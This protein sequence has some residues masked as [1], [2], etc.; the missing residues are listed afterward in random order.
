MKL[1]PV[2]VERTTHPKCPRCYRHTPEGRWNFDS[3]CDRCCTVLLD[4]FPDHWSIPHIREA[5]RAFR[6]MTPAE[7][8]ERMGL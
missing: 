3:L 6:A 4:K 5:V 7:R 1:T 2:K 8:R